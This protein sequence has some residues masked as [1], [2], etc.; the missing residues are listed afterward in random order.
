[1]IVAVLLGSALASPPMVAQGATIEV[2]PAASA[3][4]IQAATTRFDLENSKGWFTGSVSATRGDMSLTANEAEVTLDADGAIQRAV[5]RGQVVVSQGA[6]RATGE[7]AVMEGDTLTLSGDP[8]L[9][10]PQHRMKGSEMT[11]KVGAK[12]ERCTECTVVVEE[13]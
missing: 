8:M 6:H 5:A 13:R 9:T 10:S 11:F 2:G 1:M 7:V 3:L 12:T 4:V